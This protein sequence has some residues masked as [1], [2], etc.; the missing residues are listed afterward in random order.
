VLLLEQLRQLGG[1]GRL[2]GALQAGHQ[3]HRRRAR[4][5]AQPGRGAAHQ[6]GQLLVD[7]L[8]DLLAR[9]E[10]ALDLDPERALLDRARELLDDLEVDIGL[11]QRE[12][13]LAHRPGDVLLG[14]GAALAHAGERALELLGKGVEHP[15]QL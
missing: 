4:R 7:D 10:L 11:E 15:L 14:Q 12:A 8:D 3:D 6:R 2:T 5:E 13:D 1:G 9:V